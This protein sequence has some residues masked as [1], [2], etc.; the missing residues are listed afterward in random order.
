[1]RV[2]EIWKG[3]VTLHLVVG[4]DDDQTVRKRGREMTYSI[5]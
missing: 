3:K 5:C 2:R 1:M 4:R